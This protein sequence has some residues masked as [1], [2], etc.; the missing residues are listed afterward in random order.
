MS[1]TTSNPQSI[2]NNR[3]LSY[4]IWQSIPST[5]IFIFSFSF[6]PKTPLWSFLPFITFQFLFS[7][8]LSFISSASSHPIFLPRRLKLSLT[9]LLF[10]TAS[11]FSGSVA[12]L[13]LFGFN[14]FG[15]VGLRGFLVGSMFGF[16]YVF[17]R[18]WVLE[19][20]IIQVQLFDQMGFIKF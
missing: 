11:A 18:R 1:P 5:L 6:L 17:K 2:L 16:H 15:R 12:A 4:L 10:V 19:F 3:F 13:S 14:D 9:F 20:P 8:T 7:V